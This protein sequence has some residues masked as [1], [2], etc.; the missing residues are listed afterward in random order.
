MAFDI[1]AGFMGIGKVG[2]GKFRATD[3][4]IANNQKAEFFDHVIGLND[5][6]TGSA[7]KGEAVG[8]IQKQ[9][10]LM[11]PGVWNVGGSLSYPATENSAGLF[12]DYAKDGS[13][14]DIEFV[15][16]CKDAG[17]KFK[18]CRMNTLDISC[19]AGEM[20]QISVDV[21]VKNIEEGGS[22]AKYETAEKFITWDKVEIGGAPGDVQAFNISINNNLIPIYSAQPEL[23]VRDLRVGMQE[24]TGSVT[25]YLKKGILSIDASTVET[26]LSFECPGLSFDCKCIFLPSIPQGSV[27]PMVTTIPFIGIDSPFA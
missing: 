16:A 22:D 10:V 3:C 21:L 13:Y 23:S 4:S 20:L 14:F 5:T 8:S 15:Y 1:K 9:K 26:S 18:D 11:R 7:T 12:F 27:G 25:V 19:S 17:R 6:D 24:V 2:G